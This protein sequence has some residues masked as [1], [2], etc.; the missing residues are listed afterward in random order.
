MME[1]SSTF[2]AVFGMLHG[3]VCNGEISVIKSQAPPTP[4]KHDSLERMAT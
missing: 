3:Y 4:A 2:V 1:M